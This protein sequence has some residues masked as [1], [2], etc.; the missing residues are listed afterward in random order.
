MNKGL[1][2]AIGAYTLWGLLPAC[3]TPFLIRRVGFQHAYRM[4]LTTETITAEEAWRIGLVDTLSDKPD[5]SI[6]R[7]LLRLGRLEEKTILDA[8]AYFQKM[9][10]L[11]E[12]MEQTA[13]AE[14]NRLERTERVRENIKNYV[15]YQKFPWEK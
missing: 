1:F 2:Y 4:T 7:Y 9:W 10:I 5:D 11:S 6:R 14:L 8:K 13:V 3:V 12:A 15:A